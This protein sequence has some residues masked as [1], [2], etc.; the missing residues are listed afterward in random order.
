MCPSRI[1]CSLFC[2]ALLSEVV[3]A[4]LRLCCC[5][6]LRLNGN[7]FWLQALRP[8]YV[9]HCITYHMMC[10][11]WPGQWSTAVNC[12]TC[13]W[14][15]A[16]RKLISLIKFTWTMRNLPGG[17]RFISSMLGNISLVAAAAQNGIY[18]HVPAVCRPHAS[19]RLL[20]YD[21]AHHSGWR[22]PTQYRFNKENIS[23]NKI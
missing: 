19:W 23:T 15:S 8:V 21:L 20:A 9:P 2:H 7:S 10:V 3:D 18:L 22:R 11:V 12:L 1:D 13:G 5:R 16:L 14:H 4:A 17:Q 6:H